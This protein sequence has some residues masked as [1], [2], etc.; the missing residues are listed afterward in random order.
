MDIINTSS[1]DEKNINIIRIIYN[2]SE[3]GP[4]KIFGENFVNNNSKKCKIK[5][6]DNLFEL[7]SNFEL[8]NIN[9]IKLYGINEITDLSYMFHNCDH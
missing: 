4:T 8:K 6:N 5:V 9:E 2:P 3:N 7:V 1:N